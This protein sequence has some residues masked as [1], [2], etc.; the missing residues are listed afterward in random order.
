MRNALTGFAEGNPVG[1]RWSLW[2]TTNGGINWDSAGMYLQQSG[3]ETGW[4]NSL[5]FIDSG[6]SSPNKMLWFGTNNS[7]IYYS[8]NF[9]ANWSVQSTAPDSNSYSILF[10][11]Y[12]NNDGLSGGNSLERTSNGGLNWINNTSIG[13]GRITGLGGNDPGINDIMYIFQWYIRGD[14]KIY[15]ST[16]IGNSWVV[17]FTAPSGMFTH[18]NQARPGGAGEVFAVRD[19]GGISYCTCLPGGILNQNSEIPNPFYL[20][21]NYPNPF[22][23]STTIKFDIPAVGNGRDRSVKL[24][25]YDV[26]GREVATLI[27]E[28]LQP[29]TY[30]VDWDASNYPSGVYFYKLEAGDYSESK[31]MVLIK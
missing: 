31:K 20:F 21:Q 10:H 6:Y 17:Q 9:G 1:G 28:Q 27:N 8:T 13:S 30:S 12:Q 26:L 23:P 2:K 22:N 5:Y 25:I 18:M 16:N 11:S 29:E 3:N 14:N 19:N 4:N 15:Y 24:V 7:R